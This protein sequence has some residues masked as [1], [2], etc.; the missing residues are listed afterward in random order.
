LVCCAGLLA[1]PASP[2]AATCSSLPF[3]DFAVGVKTVM[4]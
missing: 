2:S 4:V 1:F 3:C